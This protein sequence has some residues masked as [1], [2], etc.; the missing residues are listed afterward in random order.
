MII[1]T[2]NSICNLDKDPGGTLYLI[3][4]DGDCKIKK[5]KFVKFLG[6]IVHNTLPW[7]NHIDYISVKVKRDVG[8][9]KKASKYLE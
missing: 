2:Q 8:I 9:I 1:G 5:V 6:L 4:G 3:V 7:S